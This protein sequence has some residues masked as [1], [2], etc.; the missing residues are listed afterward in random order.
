MIPRRRSFNKFRVSSFPAILT[1]ACLSAHRLS[2]AMICSAVY[3][4]RGRPRITAANVPH[5]LWF[6]PVYAVTG[7][8]ADYHKIRSA[9]LACSRKI[10]MSPHWAVPVQIDIGWI[11]S[12]AVLARG[13]YRTA[14]LLAVTPTSA[15]YRSS[16]DTLSEPAMAP[17]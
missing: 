12:A 1:K 9:T 17:T 3:C 11:A 15:R 6:A 5:I 13:G 14:R 4:P 10:E 8:R 16:T 2:S 7:V